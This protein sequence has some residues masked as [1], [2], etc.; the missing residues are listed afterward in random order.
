[1]GVDQV[2][3]WFGPLTGKL[4]RRGVHT[5][6]KALEDDIRAWICSWNEDPRPFT[7]TRPS[8]PPSLSVWD[9]SVLGTSGRRSV[10]VRS[11]TSSRSPS[12][13]DG[14]AEYHVW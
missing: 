10:A 1:M 9:G 12:A 14:V 3:R 4:I 6:A 13:C 7:W 2:E 8:S 5:S 11:F